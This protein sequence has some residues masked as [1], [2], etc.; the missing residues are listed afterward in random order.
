MGLRTAF[1]RTL[2]LAVFAVLVGGVGA[3][4][5]AYVAVLPA[6]TVFPD[7]HAE[8]APT[9]RAQVFSA[10]F[11][12]CMIALV[13]GLGI[14]VA[15][16]IRLRSLGWP[17]AVLTTALALVAGLTTWWLGEV[18]GPGPFPERL[19]AAQAGDLV[20]VALRLQA[21]SALAIWVFA[22]VAVP[23]FMASLGPEW[24]KPSANAAPQ[25]AAG[26]GVGGD[27]L[28]EDAGRQRVGIDG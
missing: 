12:Y 4:L 9:G 10:T 14:G 13:G 23:L 7:G 2:V 16:W 21:P 24:A 19:A 6:W 28:D 27:L 25:P 1:S 8:L 20:P 5:W 15:A 26:D 11:W 18:F 17:V 22:A 3:L